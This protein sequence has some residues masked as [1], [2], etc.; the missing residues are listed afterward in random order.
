MISNCGE[1]GY[2][3]ACFLEPEVNEDD[4]VQCYGIQENQ[5]LIL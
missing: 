4:Y 5:G 1:C 3:Y 2:A